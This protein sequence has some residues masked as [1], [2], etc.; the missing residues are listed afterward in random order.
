MRPGGTVGAYVW[1]YGDGM[2]MMR[3]FWDA[4]RTVD[5]AAERWDQGQR[6]SICRPGALARLFEN[7]GLRNVESRAIVVPTRFRDFDDFWEPFL[8]GQGGAPAYC[9]ALP[10]AARD[11]LRQTLSERLPIESDGS[12]ALTARAWAAKGTA[13]KKPG[14]AGRR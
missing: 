6:F 11:K 7:A 13:V 9:A 10:D 3:Q 8:G 2:Q 12:I 14:V 4:A 5:P 1:D